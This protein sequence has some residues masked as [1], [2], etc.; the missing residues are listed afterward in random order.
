[1]YI[2]ILQVTGCVEIN[3]RELVDPVT[4][5]LPYYTNKHYLQI[6]AT[7]TETSTG[8]KLKEN[9]RSPNMVEKSKIMSFTNVPQKFKPGFPITFKVSKLNYIPYYLPIIVELFRKKTPFS[10]NGQLCQ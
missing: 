3:A 5:Y 6:Q 7:F 2:I 9:A 8:V 10:F 1:L 4:E